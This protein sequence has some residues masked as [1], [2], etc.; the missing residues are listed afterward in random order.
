MDA[1]RMLELFQTKT[2]IVDKPNAAPLNMGKGE[3]RFDHV[4]YS[5]D[6]R[7][8]ALKDINFVIPG[9]S[10]I[11]LVGETGSGKST[12]LKLIDRFYDVETGSITIDGQDVRDITL[13]R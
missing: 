12:I 13:Q 4:N 9:G 1:E 5:Y 10:T 11:A 6:P 8:P 3:V 2:T 7:K